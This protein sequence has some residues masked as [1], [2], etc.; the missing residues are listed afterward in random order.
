MSHTLA[1][2]HMLAHGSSISRRDFI[3][4]IGFALAGGALLAIGGR[5]VATRRLPEVP[6]AALVRSMFAGLRGEGFQVHWEG[7]AVVPLRLV[8]VSD[9]AALARKQTSAE[10]ERSFLLLFRGPSD[11]ALDQ[12]TYYFEHG[13][14]GGFSL[15]IVPMAPGENARYY[16]AIFNRQHA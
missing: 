15:F 9:L 7:G 2:D 4:R 11:R 12:G 14:I 5:L 8:A 3:R 1:H 16:E 10:N 13:Q 6:G